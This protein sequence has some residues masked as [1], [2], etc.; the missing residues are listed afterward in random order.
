MENFSA[1]VR[2]TIEWARARGNEPH[3]GSPVKGYE[4]FGVNLEVPEKAELEAL[5][6]SPEHA[7]GLDM[8][9]GSYGVF[10]IACL[11]EDTEF[12][13]GAHEAQLG[14]PSRSF[15]YHIDVEGDKIKPDNS[16]YFDPAV[17]SYGTQGLYQQ[18]TTDGR[19][20]ATLIAPTQNV[21]SAMRAIEPRHALLRNRMQ[22]L[23]QRGLPDTDIN[24]VLAWNS[25][26][27]QVAYSNASKGTERVNQAIFA[28]TEN[29]IV[30]NWADPRLSRGGMMVLW[31]AGLKGS[32]EKPLVHTRKNSDII[33]PTDRR[34]LGK[35]RL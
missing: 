33:L 2:E 27:T 23:N 34:N 15:G 9:V 25:L 32:S 31:D 10:L 1:E 26:C 16:N 14:N 4:G 11:D 35:I 3:I 20:A 28:Q 6:R 18:P 30:V 12:T 22:I 13:L 7:R 19:P 8:L 24:R 5:I 17:W 29:T 21:A